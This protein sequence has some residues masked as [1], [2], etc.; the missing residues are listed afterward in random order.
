LIILT[1]PHIVHNQTH[2]CSESQIRGNFECF[3]LK[4]EA[5]NFGERVNSEIGLKNADV[6]ILTIR[7]RQRQ[8]EKTYVKVGWFFCF[9]LIAR[10]FR[11]F[12]ASLSEALLAVE[13]EGGV[14]I[15]SSREELIDEP[16]VTTPFGSSVVWGRLIYRRCSTA[17]DEVG[18]ARENVMKS[19][20]LRWSSWWLWL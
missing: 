14:A 11:D 18:S 15:T 12:S 2:L 10:S 17:S 20:T 13:A 4:L 8:N 16:V 5:K 19:L 3:R 7:D 6:W 1:C 9:F